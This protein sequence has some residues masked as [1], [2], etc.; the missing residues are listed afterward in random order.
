MIVREPGDLVMQDLPP[1]V[2]RLANRPSTS[3]S[4]TRRN[5]FPIPAAAMILAPRPRLILS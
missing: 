1:L 4:W 3:R 5:A 2:V